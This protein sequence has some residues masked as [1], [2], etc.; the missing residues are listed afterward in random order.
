[1]GD[2]SKG[3]AEDGFSWIAILEGVKT[4]PEE[5]GVRKVSL[6]LTYQETEEKGA[7]D[8]ACASPVA[9]KN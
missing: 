9:G 4:N 3:K 5:T 8:R 6:A 7:L 2:K 1:M